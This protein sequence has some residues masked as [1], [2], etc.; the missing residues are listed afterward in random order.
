MASRNVI[1]T[2]SWYSAGSGL[3]IGVIQA[4]TQ[5]QEMTLS[6]IPKLGCRCCHFLLSLD[7]A[8]IDYIHAKTIYRNTGISGVTMLLSTDGILSAVL[9]SAPFLRIPR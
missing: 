7:V 1:G 3:A 2:N 9:F 5:I 8:F 6:F 4:A